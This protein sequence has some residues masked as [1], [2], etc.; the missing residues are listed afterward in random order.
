MWKDMYPHIFS[1]VCVCAHVRVCMSVFVCA[2]VNDWTLSYI[3]SFF[4]KMHAT[5]FVPQRDVEYI[6]NDSTYT[7]RLKRT[8]VERYGYLCI[9]TCVSPRDRYIIP[10]AHTADAGRV[11]AE[12]RVMT[13]RVRSLLPAAS[14]RRIRRRMRHR[15]EE[16]VSRASSVD[17]TG[18]SRTFSS[19]ASW[20][21]AAECG[22][23]LTFFSYHTG[24]FIYS[25]DHFY[26][27]NYAKI[28]V[29]VSRCRRV[30]ML[31]S[32]VTW[33]FGPV[34]KM[35]SIGQMSTRVGKTVVSHGH[36]TWLLVTVA[37]S[38]F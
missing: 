10:S 28:R 24:C 33:V 8:T 12:T 18:T 4:S 7:V 25:H 22:F 34:A 27:Y 36:I 23:F 15:A 19:D 29:W 31:L 20:R 37:T 13:S 35:F 38:N 17:E 5:V 32:G 2:C 30:R 26:Y 21:S 3:V 14:F 9:R 16:G 1:L 11:R 6:L